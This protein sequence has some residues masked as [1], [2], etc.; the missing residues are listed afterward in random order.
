M[1]FLAVLATRYTPPV[2]FVCL[3]V[4]FFS[5]SACPSQFLSKTLAGSRCAPAGGAR[6][7]AGPPPAHRPLSC[8][9][10][11]WQE[12]GD[13]VVWL[14]AAPAGAGQGWGGFVWARG[15]RPWGRSGPRSHARPGAALLLAGD[16]KSR[17]GLRS[18][19]RDGTVPRRGIASA[20][21]CSGRAADGLW[22][23]PPEL[24]RG[25]RRPP[26]PWGFWAGVPFAP[27][28]R[29]RAPHCSGSADSPRSAPAFRGL[30]FLSRQPRAGA[31]GG[32]RGGDVFSCGGARWAVEREAGA[33]ATGAA[34][35]GPPSPGRLRYNRAAALRGR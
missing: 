20:G 23:F 6:L 11:R 34:T 33:G 2:A 13:G 14:R 3:L 12:V 32:G 9:R 8:R 29:R 27:P 7:R 31:G 21:G 1:Y 26:P 10:C 18:N 30:W 19:P 17:R 25:A 22:V 5:S 15:T 16:G 4:C 28:L 35:A 24:Q